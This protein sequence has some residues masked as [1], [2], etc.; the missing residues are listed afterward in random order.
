MSETLTRI[1]LESSPAASPAA[2]LLDVLAGI[3]EGRV[4]SFA[5]VAGVYGGVAELIRRA[6][7]MRRDAGIEVEPSPYLL[8]LN[9]L[10]EIEEEVCGEG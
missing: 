4:R 8:H 6:E 10:R 1:E 3:S 5:E 7:R 9:A 2:V